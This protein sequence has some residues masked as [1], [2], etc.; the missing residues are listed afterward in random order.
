MSRVLKFHKEIFEYNSLKC[1]IEDFSHL[2][3]F[4]IQQEQS[5]WIVHI[6]NPM[7]DIDQIEGEFRNYVISVLGSRV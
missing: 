6:D 3:E 1:S 7:H 4:N 2:A 5:Y